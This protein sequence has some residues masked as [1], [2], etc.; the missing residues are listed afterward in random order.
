M[1][2]W[3]QV[4][5]WSELDQMETFVKTLDTFEMLETLYC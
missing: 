1:E 5:H 4:G 3:A 2:S